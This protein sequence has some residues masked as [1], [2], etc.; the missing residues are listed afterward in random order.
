MKNTSEPVI[1]NNKPIP[2]ELW[3]R[4]M[5]PADA[6]LQHAIR[7]LNES[8]LQIALVAS[9]DGMLVGTLT[10]GDAF[11][12]EIMKAERSFIQTHRYWQGT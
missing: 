4:A 12:R 3:R 11:Y 8:T 6:T 7:N 1:N 2:V 9:T 5:I 10:D